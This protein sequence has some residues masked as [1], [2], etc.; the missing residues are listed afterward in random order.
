MLFLTYLLVGTVTGFLAGLFGIGGGTVIV[1]MLIVLLPQ[2]GIA[3]A[4]LLPM[5]LGIC[6]H[7][8]Y[9]HRFGTTTS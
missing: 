1:P 6:H 4:Q 8:V 9:V 7:F 3:D 5:A 2:S